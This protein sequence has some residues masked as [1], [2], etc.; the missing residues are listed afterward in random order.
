MIIAPPSGASAG[1]PPPGAGRA[2]RAGARAARRR[3]ADGA[4]PR[5]AARAGGPRRRE[6]PAADRPRGGPASPARLSDTS[7]GDEGPEALVGPVS[8]A[9][10]YYPRFHHGWS[11]LVLVETERWRSIRAPRPE[12]YDRSADP[13][14][15]DNV[16][17]R[18]RSG[19]RHPGRPAR[20][21]EPAEA[22]RG[23]RS[24][25]RSTPRPSSACGRSATWAAAQTATRRRCARVRCR[26]PRT[27]SRCCT[28]CRRRRGCGTPDGSTRPLASSR[29]WRA[30]TRTTRRCP[31]PSR[32]STSAAR[33]SRRR[34][35]RGG[36]CSSSTREYAIAVLDLALAYQAAGRIDEAIAG[37]ERT[38]ELLP[39]NV[40][41]LL[42][43]AEI[44]YARGERRE[45]LRLLPARGEGRAPA[46]RWC[47]S[48]SAPSRWR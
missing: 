30:R 42:N 25:R 20:D 16:Y 23:S 28:S 27:R 21:D 47:T 39:E 15:L 40:K 17:E 18:H 2:S 13:K 34:S 14:E 5:R 38:L 24:R 6:P 7:D 46:P 32:R 9:E 1:S 11:E 12:L 29:S 4:R 37:F 26:I 35:R 44:H 10:T 3:H 48:T 8:Y 41:A 31:S 43:L 45:G 33:T 22:G 36:A 19:R